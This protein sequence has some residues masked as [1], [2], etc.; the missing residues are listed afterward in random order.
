MRID[1]AP[2]DAQAP[3]GGSGDTKCI[4]WGSYV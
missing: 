2:L 4:A 1:E 3:A